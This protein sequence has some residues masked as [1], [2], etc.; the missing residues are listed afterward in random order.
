MSRQRNHN[1]WFRPVSLG[2]RK[3]CPTCQTK[4]KAGES[5]YSH[6]NYVNAK[7]RT[8][9][10]CCQECWV[11]VSD[12]IIEHTSECGCTTTLVGYHSTLPPWMNLLVSFTEPAA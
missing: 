3:T 10:Y 2:N 4:L 9:G 8:V 6:G 5:I 1:E 7:W 12:K 11:E